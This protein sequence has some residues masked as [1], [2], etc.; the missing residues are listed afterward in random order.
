MK[1][2]ITPILF[3]LLSVLAVLLFVRL[4]VGAGSFPE[5]WELEEQIARQTQQNEE[6]AERNKELQ[7]D[8]SGIS[9]SGLT[10]I[11]D[12]ARNELG[13]VKKNETFYQIILREDAPSEPVPMIPEGKPANHVE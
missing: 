11:E 8:V 13:M 1:I 5:I 4:W 2:K 9:Q 3:L 7:A 12:H 6:Q 10:T